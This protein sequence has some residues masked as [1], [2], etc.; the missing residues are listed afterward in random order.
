[1]EFLLM[2]LLMVLGASVFRVF[3][4]GKWTRHY[5]HACGYHTEFYHL[6]VHGNPC[7][8]CAKS[9]D[10]REWTPTTYRAKWPW[11][12]EELKEDEDRYTN[13]PGPN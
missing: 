1:M 6:E 4:M 11:G 2:L 7:P 10:S 12:W 5:K 9:W 13:Y 8:R 3:L